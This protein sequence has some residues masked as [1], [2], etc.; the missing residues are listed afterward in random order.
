VPAGIELVV[1]GLPD[2]KEAELSVISPSGM[3]M[4]KEDLP[5]HSNSKTINVSRL[6]A[7]MYLLKISSGSGIICKRFIKGN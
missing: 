4:L 3:L 2:L 5:G 6:P 7:G 1:S